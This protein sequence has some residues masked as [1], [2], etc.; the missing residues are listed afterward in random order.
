MKIATIV[1]RKGRHFEAIRDVS[2]LAEAVDVMHRMSIGSVG[3][4]NGSTDVILGVLSQQELTAALAKHGSPALGFSVALF[5][6]TP[7]LTCNCEDN[8]A[9][10]MQVMTRER[11]RHVVVRKASE[12]IAGLVSLGDLVAALLEEARLEAGVLRD[13]AR[14]RL[15]SLP[16]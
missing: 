14:S 6:R 2:P 9:E 8:A 5:M 11:F 10:V 3:I 7:A 1:N 12:E 16:G 15:L 13:L 4:H